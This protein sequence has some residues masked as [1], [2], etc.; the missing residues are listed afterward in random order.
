MVGCLTG[1]E[2]A[3]ADA[4]ARGAGTPGGIRVRSR[5]CDTGAEA[6]AEETGD[7]VPN[8]RGVKAGLGVE[9]ATDGVV[10]AG[11]MVADGTEAAAPPATCGIAGPLPRTNFLGGTFGG[12][13]A[14][15]FI[16]CL[17]LFASS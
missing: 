13:L 11:A 14:S 4:L 7:V 3:F 8:A 12:G 9:A 15:D 1:V 5:P 16:F 6:E 10:C 2:V 17:V